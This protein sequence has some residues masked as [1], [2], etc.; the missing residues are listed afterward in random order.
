MYIFIITKKEDLNVG[1]FHNNNFQMRSMIYGLFAHLRDKNK[2]KFED[3]L[4][5]TQ[6]IVEFF[7]T[8]EELESL[9]KEESE[10]DG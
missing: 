6:S 7:L 9:K 8:K 1:V 2:F 4:K 3:K 5:L 10:V